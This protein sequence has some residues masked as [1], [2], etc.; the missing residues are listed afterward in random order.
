[1]IS[2]PNIPT[3]LRIALAAGLA[4][5]IVVALSF[6]TQLRATRICRGMKVEVRDTLKNG[7]V[8]AAEI[9][10]ELG[11]LFSEAAGKRI[12]DISLDE[13]EKR[14]AMIDKIESVNATAL[15]NDS[16][17]VEVVPMVPAIRVHDRNMAYYL[18]R[19][20][21]KIACDARYTMDVPVVAGN[22]ADDNPVNYISLANRIEN[23]SKWREL[24]SMIKV[25]GPNDIYLIP[26]IR[27]QVI[28]FG[29]TDD[30][31]NKLS[32]LDRFY[33]EVMPHKGWNYY[34][35][36]SVK[37]SGRLVA[38]RAHKNTAPANIVVDESSET[39]DYENLGLDQ[40]VDTTVLVN[41]AA[42]PN[43]PKTTKPTN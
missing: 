5:Y 42:T 28:A 27:G 16:I 18:N 13:I 9:E 31:D 33:K 10:R 43:K 30:V 14:L 19:A 26:D 25:D 22:F 12:A 23:D 20:G 15:T 17:L 7:F 41:K 40:L 29:N 11:S 37:W 32:R 8:K 6:T 2:K 3:L 1:M 36:I 21:K 34:D 35:T 24:I 38:T 39:N 4:L